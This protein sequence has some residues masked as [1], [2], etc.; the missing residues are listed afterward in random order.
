MAS[1]Q[2]KVLNVFL[3]D[4]RKNIF[5]RALGL[6]IPFAFV[7]TV[8]IGGL[9]GDVSL[10]KDF[11]W[12]EVT[13]GQHRWVGITFVLLTLL[14]TLVGDFSLRNA[15]DDLLTPLRRKLVGIWEVRTKGWTIQK[16]KVEFGSM[17]SHC[18]ISIEPLAGKLVLRFE[19][20]NSDV[21]ADQRIDIK[22]TAF[23]FEGSETQLVYFFD[24]AFRLREPV[25]TPPDQISAL[26]FPFLG[27]LNIN[28]G[29]EGSI[30]SMSGHWYDVNNAI[31]NLARHMDHLPGFAELRAAVEN[32]AVTFGGA[33]EFN[34]LHVPQGT[35]V[36]SDRP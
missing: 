16:G 25:G 6:S 35:P 27:V 4:L 11:P 20:H 19:V 31:Y 18:T 24:T 10:Q 2:E 29:D 26:Q 9:E 8:L 21:F 34:R 36:G 12:Y 15:R 7:M 13:P 3:G 1:F 33:L 23:S 28:F 14:L 5:F 30:D 32:G 22:T 17:L